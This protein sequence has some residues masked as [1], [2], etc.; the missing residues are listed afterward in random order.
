M[1]EVKRDKLGRRIPVFDRKAAAKKAQKT[2]EERHGPNYNSRI[3]SM[4]ARVRTRGHFGKLKDEGK[5]DELKTISQIGARE[6]NKVKA[7]KRD[8]GGGTGISATGNGAE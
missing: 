6:A 5:L 2:R 4:G 3:G 8:G 1:T 7:T